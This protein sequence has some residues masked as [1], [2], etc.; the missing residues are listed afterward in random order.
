MTNKIPPA[1]GLNIKTQA[2]IDLWTEMNQYHGSSVWGPVGK[3]IEK[4]E[5]EVRAQE[6]KRIINLIRKMR[7]DNYRDDPSLGYHTG[8]DIGLHDVIDVLEDEV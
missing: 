2:G 7:I 3:G 5:A 6:H 1:M 8:W 4:I